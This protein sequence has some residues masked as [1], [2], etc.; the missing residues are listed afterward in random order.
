MLSHSSLN[1]VYRTVWNQA[2]GAMVA[3]AEIATGGSRGGS[4]AAGAHSSAPSCLALLALGVAVAWGAALPQ[5]WANPTGAT[6]IAGQAT[7]TTTGNQLLVTTQNAAGAN[8]SAINWQSFSIPTGSST[9]FQQPTVSSTVINRVVTNTPSLIFGT[10]GSNGNLVLVNQAGVTVSAGAVVDTAGFTASALRMSDADAL[11]GRLRFGDSTLSTSGVSVQGSILARSGDVVLLGAN[12]DTS[13]DAIVQAPNGNT[14]LAAGQQIEITGRGLEGISLQVQAPT[15]SVVNL[16]TLKGDAVGIFAGTLKH[17]G[18]IQ[19]NAVSTEGGKV[20]LKA[21]GDTYVQGS[22]L[23]AAQALPAGGASKGGSVDVLG[24]RVAVAD[25]A[26]IDVSGAA[27][28]GTVLV[29]GDY[30][31]KNPDV[32]NAQFS[33][34]GPQASIRADATA[35]GDGGKVI[36]WADKTTQAYGI[37]SARGGEQG[38]NGGFVETSGHRNLDVSGAHV[39]TRAAVGKVGNWLLDPTDITITHGAVT[40]ATFTSNIFDNGAG[41]TATLT[42]GDINTALGTSNITIQTASNNR[43]G[44]VSGDIT[45]NSSTASGGA[46]L[47]A[48]G[49]NPSTLTLNAERD[50]I[51]TGTGGTTFSAAGST[52]ALSVYFNTLA[53]KTKT[54][55]GS[56]TLDGSASAN[57]TA[58]LSSTGVWDNS[59]TLTLKGNANV[60]VPNTATFNNKSGATIDLTTVNDNFVFYSTGDNGGLLT[61]GGTLSVSGNTFALKFKQTSGGTLNINNGTLSL[62]NLDQVEGTVNLNATSAAAKMW[63][64]EIH[65]GASNEFLQT[66]FTS[67]GSLGTSIEVSSPAGSFLPYVSFKGVSASGVDLV[68][69]EQGAIAIASSGTSCDPLCASTFNSA[70]FSGTTVGRIDLINNGSFTVA[71]GNIAVPISG[72]TYTGNAAYVATAGMVTSGNISTNGANLSLTGGTSVSIDGIVNTSPPASA[73]GNGGSVTLTS[74]SGGILALGIST[75]G[76]AGTT[77][78]FGSCGN[79]TVNAAT[80]FI[81]SGDII[82]EADTSTSTQSRHGGNISITAGTDITYGSVYTRAYWGLN[83]SGGSVAMTATLGAINSSATWGD[84]HTIGGSGGVSGDISL[85]G[86]SGINFQ[87]V[88]DAGTGGS[89]NIGTITLT[90]SIGSVTDL[91][92]SAHTGYVL[93]KALVI[94]ASGVTLTNPL[95]NVTQ[96]SITNSGTAPVSYW[97]A[98]GFTIGTITTPGALTLNSGGTI[99][100]TGSV[101]AGVFTLASGTWSQVAATLPSFAATDFRIAGGTFVRA[102]SGAGSTVSP[103][104]LSDIYGVQGMGSAGMVSNSYVLA[105]N[106]D[107]TGTSAWNAGS[108]FV[109]V[110]NASTPFN[111]SFNGQGHTISSLFVNRPAAPEDGLFGMLST[112]ATVSNLGVLGANITGLENVG[113]VVGLNQGAVSNVYSTGSV[114][115][116]ALSTLN[117]A[118]G[119][120]GGIVGRNEGSVSNSYSEA[121]VS[122]LLAGGF[123]GSNLGGITNSYSIGGVSGGTNGGFA[124]YSNNS[125]T[126][127]FWNSNT[128]GQSVGV[129]NVANG[130]AQVTGLATLAMQTQANYT[131]LDFTNTWVMY[132]GFTNP[133]LRSFMT[134]LTVTANSTTKD[135]DG[136]TYI[137]TVAPS[138]TPNANLLGTASVNGAGINAGT[139]ALTPSG[140]YSNQQGYII[141]YVNGSLTVNARSQS[142]WTATGAGFWSNAANWDALPTGNNVLS[143]VI[144][145]GAAVTYDTGASSVQSITTNGSFTLAGGTLAVSGTLTTPQYAQT[146]GA[147]SGGG[148]AVNGSFSQTGGTIA[149]TGPVSITQSS[150]NLSVG[151][152]S[153]SVVTLAAPTGSISQTAALSASTLNTSSATGTNLTN[154]TNSVAAFS[155]TVSGAGNVA[156]TNVGALDVT[157]VTVPNGTVAFDNTGAFTNSGAINAPANSVTITAHSPI[158][159]GG[160]INAGGNITLAANTV[161]TNST[162]TLN[163][164]LNSTGGAVNMSAYSSIYQNSYVYGALGVSAFAQTGS[165]TFGPLGYSGGSPLSYTD[166]FGSVTV[167]LVSSALIASL[168]NNFTTVFL[169]QFQLALDSQSAIAD[170]TDPEKKNRDGLIVEGEGQICTP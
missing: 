119:K 62:Q 76:V 169:D 71:T 142:V 85:N 87:N 24:N 59:G 41:A 30:Q 44:G 157:G 98:D 116:A 14:I 74:T 78:T 99:G 49:S 61:N 150:G 12:V 16:G 68:V 149:M 144:N 135:Y 158:T 159:V 139:Y 102:L 151:S 128:S 145:N 9:Y 83:G 100:A 75:S 86:H 19:A 140:L 89:A 47:V 154:T 127:S 91:N 81:S 80:T 13:A 118:P 27:G 65:T 70:T 1:H 51:F 25:Q 82:A 15:D 4:A 94:N 26:V 34:V 168:S 33:Y 29:G 22:G 115:A 153:G 31:G 45:F 105:N 162:I 37:I 166:I 2:L 17:S 88:L 7:L 156:F 5:A 125:I 131:G 161:N 32:P 148:L 64:S 103:Y 66:T 124:G 48:T 129:G 54:S 160:A 92:V 130:V 106:V 138:T 77:N 40:S 56:V 90:S 3:V 60:Y 165:I 155:A 108:G 8:H 43:G 164:N 46:I 141:S 63:V 113:G 134:P 72:V 147:L 58:F 79:V 107:A 39:D 69:G 50:I 21:Q 152:L 123:V 122:G 55:D 35:N 42:D 120:A 112:I 18:L 137:G 97:D 121:A 57:V 67:S 96:L 114:T 95:N 6:V 133:L 11:A 28:G 104:Q 143:V 146:G 167:P 93:A 163:G 110:G 36:V 101:S 109:P 170:P 10:L 73:G 136:R 38:G 111:G 52:P 84:I 20:V 23:I 126:N 132:D 117:Q 53:G